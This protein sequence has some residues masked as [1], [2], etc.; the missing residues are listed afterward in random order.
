MGNNKNKYYTEV[1]NS[2]FSDELNSFLSSTNDAQPSTYHEVDNLNKNQI[3][4]NQ[5]S[6]TNYNAGYMDDYAIE[7]PSSY[8]E[9]SSN[10]P[11]FTEIEDDKEETSSDV[12][13]ENSQVSSD[14]IVV[15]PKTDKI[16]KYEE[17]LVK[18]SEKLQKFLSKYDNKYLEDVRNTDYY[19]RRL[20]YWKNYYKKQRAKLNIDELVADKLAEN[21]IASSISTAVT[22]E[23][24]PTVTENKYNFAPAST[25]EINDFFGNNEKYNEDV[26]ENNKND[27]SISELQINEPIATDNTS[28]EEIYDNIARA[29]SYLIEAG[30]ILDITKN[31]IK[32]VS[33]EQK[34]V[35]KNNISKT[36]NKILLKS[37]KESLDSANTIAKKVHLKYKES[38]TKRSKYFEKQ[39]EARRTLLAELATSFENIYGDGLKERKRNL[40]KTQKS[41]ELHQ[42]N[43][44]LESCADIIVEN[45]RTTYVQGLGEYFTNRIFEAMENQNELNAPITRT[46]INDM[47]KQMVNSASEEFTT[48]LNSTREKQLNAENL[49]KACKDLKNQMDNE[50]DSA[51]KQEIKKELQAKYYNLELLKLNVS[52]KEAEDKKLLKKDSVRFLIDQVVAKEV[53]TVLNLNRK[54]QVSE[55]EL[56]EEITKNLCDKMISTLDAHKKDL[57]FKTKSVSQSAEEYFIFDNPFTNEEIEINYDYKSNLMDSLTDNFDEMI[58]DYLKQVNLLANNIKQAKENEK[59]NFE[60]DFTN[61]PEIQSYK[62]RLTKL[63]RDK[64]Q[65][66]NIQEKTPEQLAKYKQVKEEYEQVAEQFATLV[67]QKA[68]EYRKKEKEDALTLN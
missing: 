39:F 61:S 4:N 10:G 25:V 53:G 60:N 33:D 18:K 66:E 40:A 51:K 27:N 9:I 56:N 17:S 54:N 47:L 11:A 24:T 46:A 5:A 59:Y 34:E 52:L 49:T 26:N 23:S 1:N 20:E 13:D 30:S 65:L 16:S 28:N 64:K 3:A 63:R 45:L 58:E 37:L 22:D 38:N 35:I 29:D 8:E 21:D 2:I 43:P 12:N 6:S 67:K 7:L 68:I 31:P 42:S 55:Y 57:I 32:Y 50:T 48:R 41:I 36:V 19:K 14:E 15:N 62:V 44:D